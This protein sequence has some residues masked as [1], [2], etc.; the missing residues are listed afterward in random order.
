M[1]D[2]SHA[3]DKTFWDVLQPPAPPSSPSHSSARALTDAPRNLTDDMLRAIAHNNGVVMVNFYPSFIDQTWR[4]AWN[5]TQSQRD[6]LYAEAAAP[7]RERGKPVPYAVPIAVD[8]EFF[9]QHFAAVQPLPPL[10]SLIAHFD[11]IA[12]VAGIDHVGIGTDF[13]GFAMLPQEIASAA[14]L[15]KSPPPSWHAA[16]PPRTCTKYSAATCSATSPQYRLPPIIFRNNSYFF[17]TSVI[18]WIF[19]SLREQIIRLR[20]QRLRNLAIQVSIAP[21]LIVERIEDA[22]SAALIFLERKPVDRPLL[23]PRHRRALLQKSLHLSLFPRLRLQMAIQCQL[24]HS[25]SPFDSLLLPLRCQNPI[26]VTHLSKL[27]KATAHRDSS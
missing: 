10:D 7:Y 20:H 17:A 11:H 16:T 25:A 2:I 18:L 21:C 3:S 1:V 12:K 24:R 27:S 9:R 22:I 13:D 23:L 4:S 15:P 26:R 19:R 6:P 5:A 14:D 8:R